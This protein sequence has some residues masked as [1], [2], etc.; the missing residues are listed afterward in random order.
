MAQTDL[1]GF[2]NF[3]EITKSASESVLGASSVANCCTS[4]ANCCSENVV[5]FTDAVGMLKEARDRVYQRIVAQQLMERVNGVSESASELRTKSATGSKNCNTSVDRL[6][7]PLALSPLVKR[8]L[9]MMQAD[10]L[11]S[12]PQAPPQPQYPNAQPSPAVGLRGTPA[13]VGPGRT[14]T[15][16]GSITP[17]S[18]VGQPMHGAAPAVNAHGGSAMAGQIGTPGTG[19]DAPQDTRAAAMPGA[20]RST[21]GDLFGAITSRQTSLAVSESDRLRSPLQP[22]S[23]HLKTHLQPLQHL[24]GRTYDGERLDIKLLVHSLASSE[25]PIDDVQTR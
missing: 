2:R 15:G 20:R 25:R 4:V 23:T 14:P 6:E 5:T 7:T 24:F 17:M 8:S 18:Q 16:A 10:P 3:G 12:P 1:V 13:T 9:A 22:T 19:L 11:R 21:A